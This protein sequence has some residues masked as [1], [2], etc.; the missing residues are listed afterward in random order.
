MKKSNFKKFLSGIISAS[1]LVAAFPMSM[2]QATVDTNDVNVLYEDGYDTKTTALVHNGTGSVEL[3]DAPTD[4]SNKV[5]KVTSTAKVD[6]S[7][8]IN[9]NLTDE[10]GWDIW[11]NT[12]FKTYAQRGAIDGRP[13][14]FQMQAYF[15]QAFADKVCLGDNYWSALEMGPQ[16]ATRLLD[17]GYPIRTGYSGTG[18]QSI[19]GGWFGSS[20]DAPATAVTPDAWHTFTWI[21][22]GTGA[23]TLTTVYVDDTKLY[24]KKAKDGVGYS[25]SSAFGGISVRLTEDVTLDGESF[26]I[27]NVKVYQPIADFTAELAFDKLNAT[28][29]INFTYKITDNDLDKIVIKNP[30]GNAVTANKKLSADGKTVTF[31]FN[32]ELESSATYTVDLSAVVDEFGRGLETQTLTFVTARNPIKVIYSEDYEDSYNVMVTYPNVTKYKMAEMTDKDGKTGKVLNVWGTGE[33]EANA[34]YMN[35]YL[36]DQTAV[37]GGAKTYSQYTNFISGRPIVYE[38]DV[39]ATEAFKNAVSTQWDN[40]SYIGPARQTGEAT[41]GNGALTSFAREGD[42][43]LLYGTEQGNRKTFELNTWNSLKWVIEP[44]ND[45]TAAATMTA[46]LN[47]AKIN[48]VTTTFNP[49]TFCM[50]GINVHRASNGSAPP[51]DSLF[52]DNVKIWQCE[53]AFGLESATYDPAEGAILVSTGTKPTQKTIDSIKLKRGETDVTSL[54]TSRAW[55]DANSTLK[56]YVPFEKL[57]VSTVYTLTMPAGST[58]VYDQVVTTELTTNFTTPKSKSISIKTATVT[59][60]PSKSG[61]TVSVTLENVAINNGT[62]AWV[63]MGVYGKFNRLLGV[64][65]E[66][67][68]I[69]TQGG[70][71]TTSNLT[72][73]DDC[74]AAEEIRV[75]VW[76]APDTIV[77]LQNNE[78]VWTKPTVE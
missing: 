5:M 71:Y 77:P 35:A 75:F 17:G 45:G 32:S 11:S 60:E 38:A 72:T 31:S 23:D 66:E 46:Y 73:S 67:V 7:K 15:P 78:I 56:L 41:S 36:T 42:S 1:M 29:T 68:T 58:D 28:G 54:I 57:N 16:V 64:A 49:E 26:Y 13:L 34:H 21:V 76:D 18:H 65:D 20:K 52:I 59:S 6:E 3:A 40:S 10:T 50:Y 63:I 44:A 39:Y 33:K 27:D 4:S 12:T 74:S 48:T 14:V 70:T 47:G 22:E 51:E 55:D 8:V 69:N 61:A 9:M 19:T 53:S 2:A 43:A 25:S 62:S 24:D 30:S 37:W